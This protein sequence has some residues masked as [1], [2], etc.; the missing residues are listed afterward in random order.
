MPPSAAHQRPLPEAIS[1]TEMGLFSTK[2]RQAR[3]P[4]LTAA[5]LQG[6][7][8][9]AHV[10]QY[11]QAVV[12]P[13]LIRRREPYLKDK[14]LKKLGIQ[15]TGLDLAS[16][17]AQPPVF[18]DEKF[19]TP[20]PPSEVQKMLQMNGPS[21][22]DWLPDDGEGLNSTRFGEASDVLNFFD[23]LLIEKKHAGPPPEF[24]QGPPL[25]TGYTRWR[26]H[27]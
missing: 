9:T 8:F 25:L 21:T 17:T 14:E 13:S 16:A 20:I 15:A 24:R 11:L 27:K 10:A 1:D 4:A 12:G 7:S 2:D 3:T 19:L 18:Y 23:T 26:W 6:R 22:R 5:S